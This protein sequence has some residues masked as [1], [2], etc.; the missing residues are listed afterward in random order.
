MDGKQITVLRT[1]ISR[2]SPAGRADQD[3]EEINVS[4]GAAEANEL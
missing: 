1:S 2:Y 3:R 4:S